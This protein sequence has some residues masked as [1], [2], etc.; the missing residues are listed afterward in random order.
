[1]Y[2]RELRHVH[3]WFSRPFINWVNESEWLMLKHYN[4]TAYRQF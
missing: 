4:K 3:N 2:E 1:M